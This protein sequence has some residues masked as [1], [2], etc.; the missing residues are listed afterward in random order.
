M[1]SCA[2]SHTILCHVTSDITLAIPCVIAPGQYVSYLVFGFFLKVNLIC[3]S[4][5]CCI[6]CGY[7]YVST[8]DQGLK[9][10]LSSHCSFTQNVIPPIHTAVSGLHHPEKLQ[11]LVLIT[12]VSVVYS[13]G[14]GTC[15]AYC[16]QINVWCFTL[17][18]V[19]VNDNVLCFSSHC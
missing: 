2:C 18:A 10:C 12:V 5:L 15:N 9:T 19:F 8:T 14:C 1:F 16:S 4:A 13:A 6:S 11:C 3:R 7:S 17:C